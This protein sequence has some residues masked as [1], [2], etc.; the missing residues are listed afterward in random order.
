[1]QTF[2]VDMPRAG[3]RSSRYRQ[4]GNAVP[5][6]LAE[7]VGAALYRQVAVPAF[8]NCKRTPRASVA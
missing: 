1:M 3:R 5:V 2:P 6:K 7:A 8:E 4:I